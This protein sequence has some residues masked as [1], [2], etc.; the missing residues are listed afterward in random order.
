MNIS[1]DRSSLLK[2]KPRDKN[3]ILDLITSEAASIASEMEVWRVLRTHRD[4]FLENRI[5]IFEHEAAEIGERLTPDATLIDLGCWTGVLAAQ[6]LERVLPRAYVGIDAGQWYVELAR[7]FLPDW[8]QFRSFYLLPDSAVDLCRLDKLYFTLQDP[9]NTSGFYIRR[10]VPQERLAAMPVGKAMRPVDFAGWLRHNHD[11]AR[12]YLKI[13]IE[14]VDQDVVRALI[15]TEALP[16]VLHFELLEKFKHRWPVTRGLL[17]ARYDFVD[18][19]LPLDSTAIII[20]VR[21]GEPLRPATILWDKTTREL[22]K[23]E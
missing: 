15:R 21:K 9:L 4:Y 3:P 17:A 5:G 7:E 19:A 8:C 16:Q 13:D 6:V 12:L 20:A 14:G 23:H 22:S 18:V 2:Y 11:L 1:T 10:V